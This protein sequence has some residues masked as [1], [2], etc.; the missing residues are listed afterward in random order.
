MLSRISGVPLLFV[1]TSFLCIQSWTTSSSDI[2][3]KVI[4]QNVSKI[5][6]FEILFASKEIFCMEAPL[7]AKDAVWWRRKI[8]LPGLALFS[9]KCRA[10]PPI[11]YVLCE[12]LFL[13]PVLTDPS[14]QPNCSCADSQSQTY[15]PILYCHM[16]HN[17]PPAQHRIS[18]G[19]ARERL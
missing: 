4:C 10:G 15:E 11:S 19:A 12:E 5:D 16:F 8:G 2:Q 18:P 3:D 17:L 14:F 1:K 9:L 13:C 6:S 7:V